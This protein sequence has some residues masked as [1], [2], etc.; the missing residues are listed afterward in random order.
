MIVSDVCVVCWLTY[1][2]FRLILLTLRFCVL[3]TRRS[4]SVLYMYKTEREREYC[5]ARVRS[6]ATHWPQMVLQFALR[7]DRSLAYSTVSCRRRSVMYNLSERRP[8][9]AD[10][11]EWVR[12]GG[13]SIF[14]RTRPT[15]DRGSSWQLNSSRP[16]L[17]QSPSPFWH[18]L[19]SAG[20][21]ICKSRST[22]ASKRKESHLAE[23][24]SLHV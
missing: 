17:T 11:C 24:S 19:Y 4:W 7:P 13:Y 23:F 3:F 21:S 15:V 1:S 2:M 14:R 6:A 18:I 9:W 20:A 5:M 10:V 12:R 22:N 16:S 8:G